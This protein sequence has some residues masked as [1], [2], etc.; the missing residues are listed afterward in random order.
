[1]S[2]HAP[3]FLRPLKIS[4]NHPLGLWLAAFLQTRRYPVQ[5]VGQQPQ[6]SWWAMNQSF[7]ALGEPVSEWPLEWRFHHLDGAVLRHQGEQ[8][9]RS[10]RLDLLDIQAL[11]ADLLKKTQAENIRWQRALEEHSPFELHLN[12]QACEKAQALSLCGQISPLPLAAGLLQYEAS[13]QLEFAITCLKPQTLAYS[14]VGTQLDNLFESLNHCL[15]QHYPETV[16]RLGSEAPNAQWQC[17]CRVHI[18]PGPQGLS[19]S[20]SP[21]TLSPQSLYREGIFW[22][23]LRLIS[24]W[25]DRGESPPEDLAARLQAWD[26]KV[27]G[28]ESYKQKSDY[29]FHL[30][31]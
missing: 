7:R 8:Q 31:T 29:F 27:A 10:T 19:L 20:L 30:Q 3:P 13:E 21:P 28:L 26:Q 1:M 14:L 25:L 9:L 16:F 23:Y 5:Y 17:P 11:Y 4:G 12:W 24:R 18:Q 6:N 2:S 22:L 15:Q